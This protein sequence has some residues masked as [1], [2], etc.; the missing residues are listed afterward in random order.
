[1]DDLERIPM[2]KYEELE[3]IWTGVISSIGSYSQPQTCLTFSQT[4]SKPSIIDDNNHNSDL[5]T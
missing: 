4:L 1:M 3:F 5:E 2:A